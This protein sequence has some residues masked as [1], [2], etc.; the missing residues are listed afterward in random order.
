M[1]ALCGVAPC[2]GTQTSDSQEVY[3]QG[4]NLQLTANPEVVNLSAIGTPLSFHLERK[5]NDK[6]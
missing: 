1:Y 3:R 2:L 6:R 4:L 5:Y